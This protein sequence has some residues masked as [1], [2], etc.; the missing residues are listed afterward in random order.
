MVGGRKAVCLRHWSL[1]A[2]KHRAR[3]A[4]PSTKRDTHGGG[5]C[6]VARE[7]WGYTA[8]PGNW[9]PG[10]ICLR[11]GGGVR[12]S[13]LEILEAMGGPLVLWQVSL[14]QRRL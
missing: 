10:R 4:L 13:L 2:V 1:E 8:P 11:G 12:S 5:G 14:I 6:Y 7:W 3:S 9:V